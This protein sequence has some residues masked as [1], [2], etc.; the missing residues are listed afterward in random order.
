MSPSL[1]GTITLSRVTFINP[2]TT[3]R[4]C[5]CMGLLAMRPLTS[6]HLLMTFLHDHHSRRRPMLINVTL[7]HQLLAPLSMHR[8]PITLKFLFNGL[9]P[10]K[11]L[12]LRR[13][14]GLHELLNA[15]IM[16]HKGVHAVQLEQSRVGLPK[17]INMMCFQ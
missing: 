13:Q 4:E 11:P 9:P 3:S 15:Q 10:Y 2:L 6:S 12:P 1:T 14:S 16:S 17:H 5:F 8:D 7:I